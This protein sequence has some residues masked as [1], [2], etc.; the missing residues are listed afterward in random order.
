MTG[1]RTLIALAAVV[2]AAPAH[3]GIASVAVYVQQ[4]FYQDANGVVPWSQGPLGGLASDI[5]GNAKI[6]FTVATATANQGAGATMTR[7]GSSTPLAL[8]PGYDWNDVNY[9][10]DYNAQDYGSLN[11]LL[12]AYPGGAYVFTAP[13]AGN[14]TSVTLNFN[15]GLLKNS[16]MASAVPTLTNYASLQ[17][18][19]AASPF[20]FAFKSFQGF[21]SSVNPNEVVPYAQ[22]GIIDLSTLQ[23]VYQSPNMTSSS[24]SFTLGANTLQSGTN[25]GY[26]VNYDSWTCTTGP[27][28]SGHEMGNYTFGTFSTAAGPAVP[29]TLVDFQ[30]G[31]QDAPVALPRVI[32][33]VGAISGTIGGAPDVDFYK[34]V[35]NGG[36]F[37]ATATLTG[38]DATAEF[39][40]KL[41]DFDTGTV[42]GRLALD[43]AGNNFNGTLGADLPAGVYE[44]GLI[45]GASADPAFTISFDTSAQAPVP[46]PATAA[47]WLAGLLAV[48]GHKKARSRGLSVV[49]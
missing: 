4:N 33:Q 47:L 12:T 27:Y 7:P 19:N 26:Y 20:T 24:T 25:Y 39:T 10:F 6:T 42:I 43:Q 14:P 15:A 41:I 17:G 2:A 31:T 18:M 32:Q 22:V 5:G 23:V 34:F 37:A 44:I 21:G 49:S 3:A 45:S 13:A 46:E 35:W 8:T 1:L 16:T 9:H 36:H 40:F 48:F 30:G 29:Q 38:A 28:C 11:Q